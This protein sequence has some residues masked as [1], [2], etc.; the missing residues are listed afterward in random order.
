MIG[1]GKDVYKRVRGK[2]YKCRKK[3]FLKQEGEKRHVDRVRGSRK[4]GEGGGGD[5][6]SGK[7]REYTM[8]RTH[9]ETKVKQNK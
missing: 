5:G 1:K 4:R 7:R 8:K 3:G 6:G 2:G 9:K